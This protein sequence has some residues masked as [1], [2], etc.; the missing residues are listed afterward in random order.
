MQFIRTLFLLVI[1]FCLSCSV[2][3]STNDWLIDYTIEELNKVFEHNAYLERTGI[4]QGQI[5]HVDMNYIVYGRHTM[6]TDHTNMVAELDR[7]NVVATPPKPNLYV[8]FTAFYNQYLATNGTQTEITSFENNFKSAVKEKAKLLQGNN[9]GILFWAASELNNLVLPNATVARP[10]GNVNNKS[11]IL[12]GYGLN[13]ETIYNRLVALRPYFYPSSQQTFPVWAFNTISNIGR[14]IRDGSF[15]AGDVVIAGAATRPYRSEE[16]VWESRLMNNSNVQAGD[17]RI[18]DEA[19][20]MTA[21]EE[22]DLVRRLVAVNKRFKIYTSSRGYTDQIRNLNLQ[23]QSTPGSFD[24]LEKNAIQRL[25]EYTGMQDGEIALALHFNKLSPDFGGA[26]VLYWDVRIGTQ[27]VD[28]T[29]KTFISQTFIES[30]FNKASTAK[31][32]DVL[33]ASYTSSDNIMMDVPAKVALIREIL[34]RSLLDL[35]EDDE[36]Q[37]INILTETADRDIPAL[38]VELK[39]D[40]YDLLFDIIGSTDDAVLGIWG[41]NNYGLL[42]KTLATLLTRNPESINNLYNASAANIIN[43]T[44]FW[45]DNQMSSTDYLGKQTYR[46][47]LDANKNVTYTREIITSFSRLGQPVSYSP[48]SSSAGMAIAHSQ[49]FSSSAPIAPLDLVL[50]YDYSNMSIVSDALI[51]ETQINFVPAIFLKY[52]AD[53]GFN[54]DVIG[55]VG[56]GVTLV[57]GAGMITKVGR[58]MQVVY[59]LEMSGAVANI[60]INVLD[61]GHEYQG[62]VNSYNLVMGLI[63]I[64]NLATTLPGAIEA[65]TGVVSNAKKASTKSFLAD[66]ARHEEALLEM[67]RTNTKAADILNLRNTYIKE[68]IRKYPGEPIDANTWKTLDALSD[69]GGVGSTGKYSIAIIR[70]EIG[71][72][73]LLG[74]LIKKEGLTLDDFKY[75]AQK[76]VN[77]LT[78][79]EKTQLENI[80]NVLSKPNANTLMQKVITK[81]DIQK[82]LN[83]E[84]NNVGGFVSRAVDAK[85]LESFEDLYYG[86]RLDYSNTT[87]FVGDGS[88]GV[89]RFKSPSSSNAIIPSGGTYDAWDYPFTATGFTSGKSGRLGV[90]EWHL[91]N[92]VNF[93]DGDEI[94]QVA[95]N[96]TETLIAIYDET[97]NKFIAK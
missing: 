97:L 2:K 56:D 12:L 7:V 66:V 65:S 86:L 31:I 26:T 1:S 89:I 45:H 23:S 59:C 77:A 93:T 90:P 19:G 4:C 78:L 84:Y 49:T 54:S 95:N 76:N 85:H 60:I 75:M 61:I 94:W 47:S 48:G 44:I 37:I 50:F 35:E 63:G 11:G 28:E 34:G 74:D 88:C 6:G 9:S 79:A 21:A 30:L 71:F 13:N 82:Y 36:E 91:Q 64:S 72:V 68:W 17:S 87:F 92:R 83:G 14:T 96:G 10:V 25:Y 38:V 5:Y 32:N 46:V 53:K 62:L 8:L 39:K 43:R 15:S 58:A 16:L 69:V 81:N 70:N 73:D 18:W 33:Y 67:A 52:A 22:Q 42:M 3:A 80:R 24:G 29:T 55:L 27:L 57:V 51:E 20:I 40:N 41:E